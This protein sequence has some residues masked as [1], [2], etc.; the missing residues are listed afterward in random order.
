MWSLLHD[1]TPAARAGVKSGDLIIAI[2]D[3][4]TKHMSAGDA[5][6]LMRGQPGTSATLTLSRAGIPE[7]F[8]LTIEREE[9]SMHSVPYHTLFADS[10]GY[11]KLERF[12]QSASRELREALE[13]LQSR[14]MERLILDLQYNGGGYLPQAVE[15]ADLFLGKDKLVVFHAGRAYK[16]TTRLLTKEDPVVAGEPLIVLVNE[17]SASASEIV[18]GAIQDWDRGL[19]LGMPT[20]GKG[21]VQQIVRIDEKAEL[22]LTTGAYFTPSGRSID[23]RMRKDST[24]VGASDKSFHTLLRNRVVRGGGGITPDIE[25]EDLKPSRLYSQLAGGRTLNNR[26]F[27]FSRQYVADHPD[28]SPDFRADADLLG[29]F[30]EFVREEGFEYVS[31]A[32]A[33]LD[34]LEKASEGEEFEK[35]EKSLLNLQK[36]IDSIE[37]GHWD[38]GSELIQ[39]R[40]TFDILEKALGVR[41]AI[42]HQVAAS[43]RVQ[44]AREILSDPLVYEQWLEKTVIGGEQEE[45]VAQDQGG[46]GLE[47]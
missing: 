37:E 1:D 8:D 27:H 16:D 34:D 26:F 18:A 36:E 15:V 40:L 5:A 22:K 14:G 44:R 47:Q 43:P 2:D 31:E 6:D 21:S 11:V 4:S 35:L 7:P 13:D 23:K 3:S 46:E 17:A 33:R 38:D 10:T 39:W 28:I 24:V 32:E 25:A 41:A 9:V 42:A 19:I 20:V 45:T 30:R 29:E 12:Q